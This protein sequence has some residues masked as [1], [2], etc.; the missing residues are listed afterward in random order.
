MAGAYLTMARVTL[1]RGDDEGADEWLGRVAEHGGNRRPSR[2]SGWRL[3]AAR[4]T[5]GVGGRA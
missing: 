4:A 1:D 2:M 5:P 3:G